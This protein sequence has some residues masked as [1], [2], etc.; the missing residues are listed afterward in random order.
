MQVINRPLLDRS[1]GQGGVVV[2]LH[3]EDI[4]AALGRVGDAGIVGVGINEFGLQ[5]RMETTR[6]DLIDQP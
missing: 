3:C 6:A 2:Y 1:P 4:D 5:F